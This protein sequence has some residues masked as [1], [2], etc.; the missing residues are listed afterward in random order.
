MLVEEAVFDGREHCGRVVGEGTVFLPDCG[1]GTPAGIGHGVVEVADG[2]VGEFVV[3]ISLMFSGKALLFVDVPL[4][5]V[6][7][8]VG[9][10]RSAVWYVVA[11]LRGVIVDEG[12]RVLLCMP[13]GM[14]HIAQGSRMPGA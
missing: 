5:Q 4:L 13:E 3:C 9:D 2:V 8:Y 1:D 10:L 14:V 12:R 11:R 7:P 6:P